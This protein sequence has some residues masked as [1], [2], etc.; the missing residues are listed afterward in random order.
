MAGLSGSGRDA[1]PDQLRVTA[2]WPTRQSY[3]ARAHAGQTGRNR[4]YP[5]PARQQPFIT[6]GI[7]GAVKHSPFS[8]E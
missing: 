8:K 3:A 6:D 4:D 2:S 1:F 5:L 7:L